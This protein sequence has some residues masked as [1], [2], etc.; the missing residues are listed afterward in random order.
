MDKTTLFGTIPTTVTN[1]GDIYRVLYNIE[2][3]TGSCTYKLMELKGHSKPITQ[4]VHLLTHVD[5]GDIIE[6]VHKKT[7]LSSKDFNEVQ[8]LI[9]E[10]SKNRVEGHHQT[11]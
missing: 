11:K 10:D 6:Y 3:F 2:G 8:M 4:R 1:D 5:M 9:R 7:P